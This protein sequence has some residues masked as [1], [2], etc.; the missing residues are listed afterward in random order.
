MIPTQSSSHPLSQFLLSCHSEERGNDLDR[1]L[2]EVRV[3]LAKREEELLERLTAVK[4]AEEAHSSK[5]GALQNQV[6][7]SKGREGSESQ[8]IYQ[9][10]KQIT[11]SH[12]Y[13]LRGSLCLP[14]AI[15]QPP[16]SPIHSSCTLQNKELEKQLNETS[17]KILELVERHE[18]NQIQKNEDDEKYETLLHEHELVREQNQRLLESLNEKSKQFIQLEGDHKDAQQLIQELQAELESPR[19][20]VVGAGTRTGGGAAGE[21]EGPISKKFFSKQKKM[22]NKEAAARRRLFENFLVSVSHNIV[23]SDAIENKVIV[24]ARNR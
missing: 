21:G 18:M 17:Q 1:R 7:Q 4:E 22:L 11:F 8:R 13:S 20:A 15:Y 2:N 12:Q 19:V 23:V 9:N 10:A 5:L 3:A 24:E 14:H 6:R 16:N